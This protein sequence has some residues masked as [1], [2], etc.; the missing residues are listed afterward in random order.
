M[1]DTCL[2]MNTHSKSST[3]RSLS[4]ASSSVLSSASLLASLVVAV[5]LDEP[6][7]EPRQQTHRRPHDGG[8]EQDNDNE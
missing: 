4:W 2:T 1:I 8:S 3:V 5:A 7:P 6:E